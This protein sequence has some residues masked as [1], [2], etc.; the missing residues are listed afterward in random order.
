MDRI[1]ITGAL[2]Q[3]GTEFIKHFNRE[4]IFVLATD[5]KLPNS[6][7]L[8]EF[9]QADSL[10]KKR[11]D[12]LVK[13]Y[14]INIIYHLV[15]IL[16]ASGEKDPFKSWKL[17]MNSFQNI[18]EI[19][20]SNNIKKVFWPSSMA[21]F[22]TESK[23]DLVIQNPVMNPST[24][25]G[26]TK[27]TGEKLIE[28]YFNKFGLDIRSL[29]YPGII[30][31]ETVPGGGTTDYIIDMINAAKKGFSY[32]CFLNENTE[33]PMMYIDDAIN[34]AIKLMSTKRSNL[35]ILSSYN[36]TGFSITPKKLLI[37]IKSNGFN[38]KVDYKPDFRQKIADSWPKKIDDSFAKK[39]WDW[40][41][42]FGLKQTIKK[43]LK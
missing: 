2:G 41:P 38:L 4:N 12:E 29:R 43:A 39:D 10:D 36:I 15:A 32:S 7:P 22:G 5:I 21:V 34:A 16:S 40:N 19:S 6:K 26:I 8:C 24:M 27:L 1:L 17:N 11:I 37:E 13:K 28:Y 42:E 9:E 30:S 18:V 23:L 14:D 20:L 33:L 25:Y 3:L 35:S 31:V